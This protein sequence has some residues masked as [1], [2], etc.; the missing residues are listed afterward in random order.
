MLGT[1]GTKLKISNNQYF[2]NS[3]QAKNVPICSKMFQS[4]PSVPMFQAEKMTL[5]AVKN[6]FFL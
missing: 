1:S 6:F 3:Q 2:M 5:E 4:V